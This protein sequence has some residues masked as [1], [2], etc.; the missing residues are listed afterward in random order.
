VVPSDAKA[1]EAAPP[2]A[3]AASLPSQVVALGW[4]SLLT[5]AASEMI[6]PFLPELLKLV[7]GGAASLGLVEGI[8]EAVS[9]A[10]KFGFGA[11]SDR[12]GRRKP[13]AV[14][15]YALATAARP[16]FAL[17]AAAWQVV[18]IRSVDRVGKGMRGPPRD[19]LIAA[20]VAPGQ[21][22]RAFGVQRMMD[23]LGGAIGPVLAFALL[24]WAELPLRTL[25]VL[26]V[27][28]GVAAVLVLAVRVEEAPPSA[29]SPGRKSER[30]PLPPA[31]KRFLVALAVFSLAAS[32]D[33]FL[34]QRLLDL[35]LGLPWLPIAWVS[36][37]LAKSLVNVAGGRLSDRF[38]HKGTLVVAW[39][40]YGVAYGAFA[41]A[42]SVR[43]FWA[44]MIVYALY[45]GLSEGGQRALLADLVPAASRGRAFGLMMALEGGM[46]LAANAAFG[47]VYAKLGP[48]VAF[49]G[50]GAI[51]VLGALLLYALG[52]GTLS[53]EPP[54]TS[55]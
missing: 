19:A 21:R 40:F 42:G 47:V 17:A 29:P 51:A 35:G 8:A 28:P 50:G 24:R 33:A 1:A 39:L 55:T 25:F 48:T 13:F 5:D 30:A 38:G 22:A 12:M 10:C 4:V 49:A 53:G 16:F 41:L 15:G 52:S 43:A 34:L 32:T 18:L 9:A 23:N 11:L 54:R 36:L 44:I 26:S 7:G 2:P 27:I 14:I 20:C 45:Y 6:Y 37:Q 46:V 3:S 31:A